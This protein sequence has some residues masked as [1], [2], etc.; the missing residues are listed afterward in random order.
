MTIKNQPIT[1]RNQLIIKNQN[2]SIMEL[3]LCY[4]MDKK[5]INCYVKYT[6]LHM[7]IVFLINI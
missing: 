2:N 4:N 6:N 7:D 5:T 1:I 3:F